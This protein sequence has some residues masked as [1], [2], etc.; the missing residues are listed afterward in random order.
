[1]NTLLSIV[2]NIALLVLV[3]SFWELLAPR[4]SLRGPVRLVIGLLLVSC[5]VLPLTDALARGPT[6][7]ELDDTD[8]S[9]GAETALA[10]GQVIA[11]QMEQTARSQ[12]EVEMARQVSSLCLLSEGVQSARAAVRAGGEGGALTQISIEV[13]LVSGAEPAAVQS[14]LTNMIST[15]FSIEEKNIDCRIKEVEADGGEQGNEAA[16]QG[17]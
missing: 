1:M 4:G 11:A 6:P 9:G 15:F 5:V 10:E 8:F 14:K 17:Q 12:Y 3:S 16:S 2:R 7:W 13:E